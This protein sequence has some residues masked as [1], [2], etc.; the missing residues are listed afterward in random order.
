MVEYRKPAKAAAW[1]TIVIAVPVLGFALYY[2]MAREYEQRRAVRR[3]N[4]RMRPES[5]AHIASLARAA[6]DRDALPASIATEYPRLADY[7]LRQRDMP[8]T[9]GNEVELYED[10]EGAFAAMLRAMEAA[11]DH[12]H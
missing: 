7:M 5:R 11:R 6:H 10:G 2:F 12:I 9:F 3:R 8:V 4:S 1:L